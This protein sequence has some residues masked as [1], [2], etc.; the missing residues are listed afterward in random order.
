VGTIIR[1]GDFVD[2][3]AGF[4]GEKFPVYTNDQNRGGTLTDG[5][6]PLNN[7]SV[8]VLIQ[9]IQVL[10]TLL[11]PPPVDSSGRPATTT[12]E[13]TS[14]TG[15]QELVILAVT[16]Q[17]AE[18]IRFAQLDGT[19]SLVLRSPLDF[20][21]ATGQRVTPSLAP[22]TGVVLKTLVDRYG[23]LVPQIVQNIFGKP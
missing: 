23:V 21:D 1:A 10:G 15:Q 7:T 8:K 6:D 3:V 17:Q 16:P 14:L 22:T 19:I 13:V 5:S 2:V 11:P 18:V 4:T 12:T 20:V 9:G